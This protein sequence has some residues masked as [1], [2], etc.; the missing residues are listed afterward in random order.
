SA[1]ITSGAENGNRD[2]AGGT[3]GESRRVES[4]TARA[5]PVRGCACQ[6]RDRPGERPVCPRVYFDTFGSGISN[7]LKSSKAAWYFSCA[8]FS[9]S[10]NRLAPVELSG[11]ASPMLSRSFRK[12]A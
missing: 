11:F 12:P 1:S 10:R 9:P 4:Q 3:P 8:A 5:V 2:E 6:G 7:F